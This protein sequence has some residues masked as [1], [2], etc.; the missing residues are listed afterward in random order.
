MPKISGYNSFHDHVHHAL[1]FR[2]TGAEIREKALCLL[3]EVERLIAEGEARV[4]DL[5]KETNAADA[6]SAVQS[7]GRRSDPDRENERFRQAVADL[8]S[9]RVDAARLRTVAKNIESDRE[10]DLTFAE[11]EYY[12]F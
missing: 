12:E 11:L 5:S 7:Y 6:V 4:Q 10:F 8:Q 3:E 9:K 1:V 2:K